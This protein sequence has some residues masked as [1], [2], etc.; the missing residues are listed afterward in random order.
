MKVCEMRRGRLREGRWAE[1]GRGRRLGW[2]AEGVE[3]RGRGASDGIFIEL[4]RLCGPGRE[5][6]SPWRERRRK[7]G[8]TRVG[9]CRRRKSPSIL[10]EGRWQR[11]Y[12]R[13]SIKRHEKDHKHAMFEISVILERSSSRIRGGREGREGKLELTSCVNSLSSL[14]DLLLPRLR[15]SGHVMYLEAIYDVPEGRFLRAS[16]VE[17]S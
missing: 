15:S 14:P 4:S 7:E 16:Y 2:I 8:R 9:E 6:T 1:G 10:R 11:P 12:I 5:G 13:K 17:I 3:E